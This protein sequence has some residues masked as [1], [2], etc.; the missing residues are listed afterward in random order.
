MKMVDIQVIPFRVQREQFHHGRILAPGE[1]TQT[2]TKVI[3]DE[4]AEGYYFGGHGHGDAD[5]LPPDDRAVMEGRLKDLVVGQDPYDRER[6]WHWMWVA[7]IPEHLL[8]VLDMALWDVQ[9]RAPGLPLYKLLGGCRDK[10]KAYASTFPN[11]G[12]VEEYAAHALACK[13]EGYTH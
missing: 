11:M 1:V 12:S 6:F 13:E 9:A 4:G 10:V 5:G 3:T 8:S 7:N 2:L